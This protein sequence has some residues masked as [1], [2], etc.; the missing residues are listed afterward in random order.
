M[1]MPTALLLLPLL[2][3]LLLLLCLHLL[4]P[5]SPCRIITRRPLRRRLVDKHVTRRRCRLHTRCCGRACLV[6]RKRFLQ[7]E[8]KLRVTHV[9]IADAIH[10]CFFRDSSLACSHT[11]FGLFARRYQEERAPVCVPWHELG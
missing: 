7:S 10:Y 11:H 8:G 2:R 5:P 3:L 1:L 4:L 6:H 9:Q